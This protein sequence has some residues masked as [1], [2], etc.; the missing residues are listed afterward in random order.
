M[1]RR[2]ARRSLAL[3]TLLLAASLPTPFALAQTPRSRATVIA[4]QLARARAIADRAKAAASDALDVDRTEAATTGLDLV[5][6]CRKSK[7]ECA[8]LALSMVRMRLSVRSW[9]EPYELP[10]MCSSRTCWPRRSSPSNPAW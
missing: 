9:R 3:L 2:S 5:L 1:A 8:A 6:S 10:T 7:Q 4:P